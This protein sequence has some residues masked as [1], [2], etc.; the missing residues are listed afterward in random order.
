MKDSEKK[1]KLRLFF[2]GQSYLNVKEPKWGTISLGTRGGLQ[3]T[4][5]FLEKYF[6]N[7]F[8][9]V[10]IQWTRSALSTTSNL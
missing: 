7:R 5:L 2:D 10:D 1:N 3:R 9:G 8:L 4:E 6:L